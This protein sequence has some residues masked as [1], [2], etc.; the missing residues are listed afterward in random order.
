MR[1]CLI[2]HRP[3]PDDCYILVRGHLSGDEFRVGDEAEFVCGECVDAADN[4]PEPMEFV[5]GGIT[6]RQE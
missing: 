3:V 4:P 2:C 5:I 1:N 6:L